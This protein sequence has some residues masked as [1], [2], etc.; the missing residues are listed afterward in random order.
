MIAAVR[1]E[2]VRIAT[3]RSTRI[4]LVLALVLAGGLAFLIASPHYTEFNEN[5]PVGPELVE[6]WGAFEAPLALAAVLA[7][8][9]AA[10]TIGQEYRF[11]LIR[12][13]LTAF[14][15]RLQILTAK[16]LSVVLTGLVFAVASFLGSWIG[17]ALRGYP[18]RPDTAPEPVDSTILERGV[19]FVVL[20]ALSAF[21][22]AGITRQTALGIAVPLVSGLIVEQ[23]LASVLRDRADW[24]GDILPWSNAGRWPLAAT[25]DVA[26][27]DGSVSPPFHEPPVGWQSIGIFAVWVAL[28]VVVEVVAFLRRD[29]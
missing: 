11:G 21:A 19:L 4:C 1:Y 25:V 13:T 3:V 17:V 26:Q 12:L 29:A 9:V 16:I 24:L 2:W 18:T 28:F 10:Q 5:G 14:P 23:I 20:W 22:I 15:K 8:V 27:P 7:S 6:W